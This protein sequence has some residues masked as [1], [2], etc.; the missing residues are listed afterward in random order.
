MH[1]LGIPVHLL[2]IWPMFARGILRAMPDLSGG[3]HG[4]APAGLM[5]SLWRVLWDCS[6]KY[7][8]GRAVHP[9]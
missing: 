1:F 9:K 7:K 3:S 2:S 8:G 5:G 4:I 6:V